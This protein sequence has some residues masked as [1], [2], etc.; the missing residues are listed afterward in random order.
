M[1][2][3]GKH[4]L[5]KWILI[6]GF[7]YMILF[8][9]GIYFFWISADS[10]VSQLSQLIGIDR[11]LHRQHNAALSFLFVMGGI[12]VRLTMMFFYFSL[13]KYLFLIIGSRF[14]PTSAKKQNPLLKEKNLNFKGPSFIKTLNAA[15][16]WPSGTV[17]GKRFIRFPYLSYLLFRLPAGSLP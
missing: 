3:I 8:S 12:M 11:W 13:F 5:W 7:C 15:S 2:F 9:V 4:N 1:C 10:A 14:S 16:G 17:S 6:P